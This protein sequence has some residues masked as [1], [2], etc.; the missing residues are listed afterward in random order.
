M[1]LHRDIPG[2]T[3]LENVEGLRQ[4]V[5]TRAELDVI[6]LANIA[7]ATT[8]Y[9]ARK[10]T[11]RMAPFTRTWLLKLHKEMLG[12]V[13]RWAGTLRDSELNIGAPVYRISPMLEELVRDL[14]YWGNDIVADAAMLHARAVGIHPFKDGNGRWARLLANIWSKQNDGPVVL[15]P[16][17]DL[18][19]TGSSLRTRYIEAVKRADQSEYEP[20]IELHRRYSET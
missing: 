12:D 4:P 16:E 7:K 15:W 10:P 9:L 11:R 20:L 5:H 8:K 6:E 17:P 1:N 2:A 13:W 18:R 3:P 19:Q 14:A